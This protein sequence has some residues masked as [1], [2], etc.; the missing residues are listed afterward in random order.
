[1]MDPVSI[2]SSLPSAAAAKGLPRPGTRGVDPGAA[3]AASPKHDV[4]AGVVVGDAGDDDAKLQHPDQRSASAQAA[5][6]MP[7]VVDAVAVVAVSGSA[8]ASASASTAAAAAA[9]CDATAAAPSLLLPPCDSLSSGALGIDED[10][11][12]SSSG[13]GS[14]GEAASPSTG[15]TPAKMAAAAAAGAAATTSAATATTT[16]TT[17]TPASA[18]TVSAGQPTRSVAADGAVIE[19]S[20]RFVTTRDGWRL[21]LRRVACVASPGGAP[22][23][24]PRAHPVV[25]C[26]GLASGGVESFDPPESGAASDPTASPSSSSP[27]PSMAEH[28]ARLGF[29]VWVPDLR[30]SGRSDRASWWRR[31]TWFCVDD[32]LWHD[33]P[34]VVGAVLS[35][36]GAREL[37][38]VGHSMGGMLAVGA[39]SRGMAC[40]AAMRSLTLLGSG[41]F[42]AGSWHDLL[43]PLL[44]RFAAP[45]GFHAGF[46]VSLLA[47]LKNPLF[48][49]FAAVTRALFVVGGNVDAAAARVLLGGGLLGFI[50]PRVVEQLVRGLGSPRGL[51]S[52]DGRW[53]YADPKALAHDARPV[54]GICGSRDLFCPPAGALRTVN[55]FGSPWRRFLFLGPDYGTAAHHYNHFCT[56]WGRNAK[57]EVFAHLDKFLLEFDAP[58]E[59]WKGGVC[60]TMPCPIV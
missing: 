27:V 35:A 18:T 49:P 14:D 54:F 30:G 34:A 60:T 48:A 44:V 25:L 43:A 45:A 46:F 22:P 11:G 5:A 10:G 24:A 33:V 13:G 52:A 7:A 4:D 42:G 32:H 53:A 15:A 29:D 57:E 50:P 41:C 19:R 38:W 20:G 9:G 31:S 51:A 56:L 37:H 55:M 23:P 58:R 6:A 26:P 59:E 12:S 1:M 17:T 28:L 3:A 39:A 21:Y 2:D 36:T 40:A 8:S 16:T 47:R